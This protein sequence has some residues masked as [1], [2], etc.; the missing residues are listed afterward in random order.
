MSNG[1]PSEPPQLPVPTG[2]VL[3]EA[4]GTGPDACRAWAE[5][6][7][8]WPAEQAVPQIVMNALDP[9][10]VELIVGP[11]HNERRSASHRL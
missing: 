3:M 10:L 8:G 6:F 11:A 2:E 4:V 1:K 7:L 9:L 5:R